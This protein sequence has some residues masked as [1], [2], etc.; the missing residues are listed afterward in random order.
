MMEE[1]NVGRAGAGAGTGR[2]PGPLRNCS[3]AV[4]GLVRLLHSR[5]SNKYST[6][7]NDPIVASYHNQRS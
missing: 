3:Q 5:D 4:L 2:V 1:Q 7:K 6:I